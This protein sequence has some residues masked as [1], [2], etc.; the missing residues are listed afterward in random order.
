MKIFFQGGK[1][2]VSLTLMFLIEE[3]EDEDGLFGRG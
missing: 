2:A 3:N 1:F